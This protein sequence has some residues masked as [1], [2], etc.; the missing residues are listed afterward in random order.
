[1][2]FYKIIWKSCKIH[3]HLWKSMK[4]LKKHAKSMKN[5]CDQLCP[6]TATSV[7]VGSVGSPTPTLLYARPTSSGEGLQYTY[8]HI[9]TGRPSGMTVF[10]AA[11]TV[12]T[13]RMTIMITTMLTQKAICKMAMM[14][15]VMILMPIATMLTCLFCMV[16]P[17]VLAQSAQSSLQH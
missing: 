16:F 8:I 2:K 17:M 9:Y 4:I 13:M 6:H 7:E 12:V 1:M 15:V 10:F 5:P 11:F 3:K 14:I